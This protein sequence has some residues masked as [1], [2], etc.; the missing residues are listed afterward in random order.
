MKQAA[1]KEY[2]TRQRNAVLDCFVKRPQE[3]LTAQEVF[4]LLRDQGVSIGRTTVYRAIAHLCESGALIQLSDLHTVTDAP[5]RYQHKG[6]DTGHIS[7]RCS[8]CG[9]IAPLKCEAVSAFEQHV[10]QDH[11]FT[12]LEEECMLPGLCAGCQEKPH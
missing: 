11:G 10:S 1:R 3:G 9:L 4:Q 7:V 6:A 5:K 2:V 8:Q 12:L